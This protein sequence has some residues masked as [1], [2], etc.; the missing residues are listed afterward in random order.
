M[1]VVY[2]AV[3]KCVVAGTLGATRMG[4]AATI[5]ARRDWQPKIAV[6][7]GVLGASRAFLAEGPFGDGDNALKSRPDDPLVVEWKAAVVGYLTRDAYKGDIGA[8]MSLAEVYNGEVAI[9]TVDQKKALAWQVAMWGAVALRRPDKKPSTMRDLDLER[10]SRGM[11][12]EDIA[13]AKAEG[14][15]LLAQCCSSSAVPPSG[16]QGASK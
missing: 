4:D 8:M 5:N 13:A 12:P 16:Q 3:R 7:A 15:Q 6:E 1:F 11:S 2:E 9:A 10:L 14:A